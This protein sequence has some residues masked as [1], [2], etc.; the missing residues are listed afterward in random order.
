MGPIPPVLLLIMPPG[1]KPY[2]LG[3]QLGRSPKHTIG[4]LSPG[5]Y[6]LFGSTPYHFLGMGF[7]KIRAEAPYYNPS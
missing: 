4:N 2:E 6:A 1:T 7:M 5:R 3:T